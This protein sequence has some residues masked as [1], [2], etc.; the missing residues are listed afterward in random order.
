MNGS[1]RF[2]GFIGSKVDNYS[3]PSDNTETFYASFDPNEDI[4]N[5]DGTPIDKT[6][7]EEC[8]WF[9]NL[10]KIGGC[11]EAPLGGIVRDIDKTTLSHDDKSVFTAPRTG[12]QVNVPLTE[13]PSTTDEV[14]EKIKINTHIDL[15]YLIIGL[16]VVGIVI[17][18][19][20][21]I[22]SKRKN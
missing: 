22:R 6:Q 5:S 8:N 9:K 21:Y 10:F 13:G 1:K 2:T 18:T 20:F 14:I 11:P 15:S 17:A 19:I 3:L 7:R 12:V 16:C 4:R